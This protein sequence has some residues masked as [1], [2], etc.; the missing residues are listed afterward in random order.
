MAAS[1]DPSTGFYTSHLRESVDGSQLYTPPPGRHADAKSSSSSSAGEQKPDTKQE[2]K[3]K[4]VPELSDAEASELVGKTAFDVKELQKLYRDAGFADCRG[5]ALNRDEFNRFVSELL[6]LDATRD[7][8][9]VTL[10]RL[11][12]LCDR[13]HNGTIE[14]EEL[15]LGMSVL[16]KGTVREKHEAMFRLIDL[17][18]NGK[19]SRDEVMAITRTLW[20]NPVCKRLLDFAIDEQVLDG[21]EVFVDRFF[22]LAD[23]DR[24]GYIDLDEYLRYAEKYTSA[25]PDHQYTILAN[26]T[27][28]HV[29]TFTK[30]QPDRIQKEVSEIEFVFYGR[31]QHQYDFMRQFAPTFFAVHE[32]DGK[33]YVEMADLTYGFEKPCIM[34]VKMGTSTAGEDATPDKLQSMLKKDMGSTTHSL[35]VRVTG[36]KVWHQSLTPPGYVRQTKSWGRKLTAESLPS[37]MR[38]FFTDGDL[39]HEAVVHNSLEKLAQLHGWMSSQQR[40]RF[41]SSSLL[42]VY[43]AANP[44]AEVRVRMIDFAHVF[45]IKDNGLDAG[46]LTGL[47]N[48]IGILEAYLA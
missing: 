33:K 23:T 27:G 32:K 11:F 5:R 15:A 10:G 2:K 46:Y 13:D 19:L 18:G 47:N 37:S 29:G 43:D 34:D 31:L 28:G 17:D 24:N 38:C 4:L 44:A 26:Q 6:K 48:L 30:P 40:L 3:K 35:G 1:A 8:D 22:R 20:G 45:E 16:S 14:F 21:L 42:F 25:V 9:Q 41:F 39:L 7:A 36:L 12:E